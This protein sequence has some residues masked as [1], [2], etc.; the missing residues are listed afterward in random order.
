MASVEKLDIVDSH[1]EGEPTR[2]IVKGGPDLGEGSLSERRERFRASFDHVRSAV[3]H[4]PRGSDVFVGALLC[5]PVDSSCATGVIFFNNVGFLHMCGHGTMGVIVTLA[6]LGRLAAG[7]HRV[8]TPAGVVTTVLHASGEV[9]VAN[10]PAYRRASGVTVDVPGT[11]LVTGDIAWGGNW[12]YLVH[13]HG[14]ALEL[15]QV[16]AL[17]AYAARVRRA[18]N[19]AGFPE[20]DHVELSGPPRRGDAHSRNFVLCPGGAYDRSPCGTGTCAR[21]ACLAE[22]GKLREGETWIQESIT[23]S[24]F[25]ASYR[26]VGGDLIPTITGRAFVNGTATLLLDPNDPYRYGIRTP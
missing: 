1:T 20:V 12:F 19:D 23:G 16:A 2:V 15:A 11:G 18:V 21:V 24:A 6:H 13:D 17:T 5:P 4:E 10:V 3:V 8:E 22:E 9:S 14:L 7:A 26:R 25:S